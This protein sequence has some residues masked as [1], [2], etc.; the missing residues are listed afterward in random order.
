M[1]TLDGRTALVTGGGRG[2][3][4]AIVIAL[5]EAGARVGVLARSAAEVEAVAA[6]VDGVPVPADVTDGAAVRAAVEQLGGADVLVANAGVVW[7]LGRPWEVDPDGWAAAVE[8]NLTGAFRCVSAVLPGMLGRG[9]GRVVTISSG[10]AG[11]TGMP[12]ANAYSAAKAGLDMLTLNLAAEL[13]GTG[14]T[15]NAVRPGTVEGAMQDY[16]RAQPRDQVG[17]RFHDRFHGLFRDG[18]LIDP[19]IPARLVRAVVDSDLNGEVIDV[20][21]G[22]GRELAGL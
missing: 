15:A 14:V 6:E 10:A 4:R 2:I 11:G 13:T 5:A 20:R 12:S 21:D 17:E 8:I 3:G 19:A 22:R 18:G 16:M 9:W 7:P 1:G